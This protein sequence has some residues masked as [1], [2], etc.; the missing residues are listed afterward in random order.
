MAKYNKWVFGALGWAF[1][2][3]IGGLFGFILGSYFDYASHSKIRTNIEGETTPGD[4]RL[5]LLAL[6]AAV[7]KVDRKNLKVEL[8]FIK[9]VFTNTFGGQFTKQSMPLLKELLE[10]DI[11]VRDICLQIRSHMDHAARLELVNV[12]FSLSMI[13][14]E[15]HPAE[16]DLM[17]RIAMW[18][19]ITEKDYNSMHSV[20][21]PDAGWAYKVLEVSS[22]ASDDEV[23]KAYRRMAMKYHP[24]RVA[25]LGDDVAKTAGEKF[26]AVNKAW[27][28]IKKERKI[29]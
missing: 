19:G 13:D 24:D 20:H 28:E 9:Q 5:A 21:I 2:G 3:P 8:D 25:H 11:P 16:D 29:N 18:L 27:E 26:K 12:L 22:D 1:G 6:L 17:K 23:R 14:K 10:K 7:M 4:F 15:L